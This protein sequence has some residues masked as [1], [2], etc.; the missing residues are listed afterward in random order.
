M[1]FKFN[2]LVVPP[3]LGNTI[4]PL[5][6]GPFKCDSDCF[7][8]K[9][10]EQSLSFVS[11][12]CSPRDCWRGAGE[13]FAREGNLQGVRAAQGRGGGAVGTLGSGIEEGRWPRTA[14]ERRAALAPGLG[15][16]QRGPE[17]ARGQPKLGAARRAGRAGAEEGVAVAA[18]PV[19]SCAPPTRAG[20][21]GA[22]GAGG[23]GE[24]G[25]V[26]RSP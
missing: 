17:R 9:F 12:F 1:Y 3:L 20:G 23:G 8:R 26:S 16:C 19:G 5:A 25:A 21:A 4:S 24:V 10:L 15:I 22:A 14:G 11:G 7:P 2:N 18:Q 13:A 6:I